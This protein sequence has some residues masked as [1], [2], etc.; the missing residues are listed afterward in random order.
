MKLGL[1][2]WLVWFLLLVCVSPV[3]AQNAPPADLDAYVAR[4]LKTFEV[5]GLSVAI[6]KDGKVVLARGYGVRKLG[7]PTPVDENTLLAIGSN[8]KA[9]TSAALATLVD[10]GKISWDDPVYERL[11]GFQM[12]D[13]YVSHEMTI[14]DLLTHRS[15]MGLGEGDLLFWP[16]T[17]FTRAEI[18]YK[19]RFMKPA[20]SFRSRFAYDNLLYM[21]A[22]QII[23]A[24]TG[25]SWEDY[26]REKILRPL[27]MN[28]TNLSNADFK[29]GDNYAWPHSKVDG[30]LQP[31]E[32]V[33]LDNAGPAGSIN[34]SA[35]EMAKWALVQLNHGKIPGREE[36]IF[37]ERQ[38][39][40][41]WSAQTILPIGAGASPLAA[42]RP[43]FAAYAL[44]WGLSD[45]HGRKMVGHTG[46]V[47]GM[48]SRV[49]LVPEENLGVVILTNAEQ[50]GAF[51]SIL[52]HVLDS[53]FGLA[54]TD[55]IEAHKAA[56]EQAQKQGAE[57]MKQLESGRAADSK[58]SLS[59]EKYAGVYTDPW[60]GPVTIRMEGGKLVF[61]LD[62]TPKA[63]A[64]LQHW[65]YDTFKAHWRDRTIEDAFLTFTLKPDGA[66][67]HISMV[68]VSPLADFSFDYQDLYLTPKK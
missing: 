39:R 1:R 53:Y 3:L 29:P 35:A 36:R 57:I 6:V 17:T 52:Y 26:V 2:S 34:S 30:K 21:T 44:G 59:I 64:D 46:G 38:S 66:I 31:I 63:V 67:D 56:E 33:N 27:G 61:T 28:T 54:A 50:G 20:S 49:M 45:Y 65:Q 5:P 58:P 37:S 19:L 32:F 25:K 40:E 7:E 8:T 13:P 48:V 16:H 18:I 47:A 43:K 9:F 51:D 10:E 14:R 60:Y 4:V 62:H 23:P 22:G 41:M 15:G 68:A 55:W 12:Y 24:V 42:K 11:T